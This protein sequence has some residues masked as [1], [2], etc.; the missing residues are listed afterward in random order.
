M[1]EIDYFKS[2]MK[3]NSRREM[4]REKKP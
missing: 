4:E 3:C 1:I 2:Y